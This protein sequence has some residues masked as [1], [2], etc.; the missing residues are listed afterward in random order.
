M[1]HYDCEKCGKGFSS[2]RS[3]QRFCS[4]DC[5]GFL[6]RTT[7]DQYSRIDGDHSLYL[8]R[9][10]YKRNNVEGKSRENITREQLMDLWQKQ[11]GRCAISNVPMTCRAKRGEKFPYNAS[12]DRIVPGAP[13]EFGNI[14]LVCTVINSLMKDFSKTDFVRLCI[15]VAEKHSAGRRTT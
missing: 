1:Y 10:L 6:N 15:S 3:R 5:R 12:I 8:N 2:T 11:D 13:Y 7:A 14:Q 9:L 4:D